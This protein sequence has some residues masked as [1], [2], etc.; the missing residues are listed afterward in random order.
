MHLRASVVPTD[1]VHTEFS[2]MFL[3]L[4]LQLMRDPLL[5]RNKVHTHIHSY[6]QSAPRH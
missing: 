2:A 1:V 4:A 5:A 6:I 3:R